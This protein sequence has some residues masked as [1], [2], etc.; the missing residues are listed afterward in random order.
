MP[1]G[2]PRV[3]ELFSR[4]VVAQLAEQR[5]QRETFTELERKVERLEALMSTRFSDMSRLLRSGEVEMRLEVLE[6]EI[7]GRFN[8]IEQ[9]LATTGGT[10]GLESVV[11]RL[12]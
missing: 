3:D 11:E 6:E 4:A 7:S 12:D 8:R 1:D 9:T 10:G 5:A 2:V